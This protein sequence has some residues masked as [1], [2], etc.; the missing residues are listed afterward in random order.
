LSKEGQLEM[1]TMTDGTSMLVVVLAAGALGAIITWAIMQGS[2]VGHR[3]FLRKKRLVTE[4]E[5]FCAKRNQLFQDM[6][7][8]RE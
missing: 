6:I 1:K 3:V 8:G 5:E 4:Y 2:I 7:D